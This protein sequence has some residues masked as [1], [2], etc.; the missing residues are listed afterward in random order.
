M[1]RLT[2]KYD[3]LFVPRKSC[4]IDCFGEADD[5]DSCDTICDS[6]HDSDC[7]NCVIQECFTRLGEYED[8]GLTPPEIMELKERDKPKRV[9]YEHEF[10]DNRLISYVQRCESCGE[11]YDPSEKFNFCPNCGQRILRRKVIVKAF[12][13]YGFAGTEME[14]E[15]EF[16]DNATDEEIEE[17][18]KDIVYEQVDWS[19]KKED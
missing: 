4:T 11:Q 7:A 5:C 9:V 12:A 19:W 18:M 17:T 15:E 2:I 8:T 10:E 16:P 6:V 13:N 1:E 14:F 3:G